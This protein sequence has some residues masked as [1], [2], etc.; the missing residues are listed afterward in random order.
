MTKIQ[1]DNLKKIALEIRREIIKMLVPAVSHHIGCSLSIVEILT[2][3]YFNE[4]KINPK[5]PKDPDR[6]IFILSKG[7][8]GASL[9]ATLAVAGFYKK[10]LLKLY[11]VDGG[12]LPEHV[13]KVVSGIEISTGSLGHGLPIGIGF[14]TAFLNE[15]RKNRV[16]VIISD[17]EL[18]EGSTWEAIMFAGHRRLKNII[19][20]VDYNK[21]Q[22]YGST[23]EVLNLDPLNDKLKAFNWNTYETAGH[24][25]VDIERVFTEIKTTK[26]NLPHFIIAHTIKGKGIKKFEGKFESHYKSIDQET[27]DELLDSLKK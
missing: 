7:H 4:M 19:V 27:K 14:A 16:F 11:D 3:L 1:I 13:T 24:D 8:A 18:N 5:N 10:G 20:I 15:K 22:G 17:G 12:L 6:D 2:N 9:Y 21:F 26:N 25:F 23:T